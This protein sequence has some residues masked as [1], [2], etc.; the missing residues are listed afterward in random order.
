MSIKLITGDTNFDRLLRVVTV[1]CTVTIKIVSFVS[2]G[3]VT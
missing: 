2:C 3:E 1:L